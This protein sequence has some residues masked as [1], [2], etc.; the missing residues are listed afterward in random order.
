MNNRNRA[1]CLSLLMSVGVASAAMAANGFYSSATDV[2]LSSQQLTSASAGRDILLNGVV[3]DGKLAAGRNI[4]CQDCTISGSVAAGYDVQLE[5]CAQV[6]SVA[7]GHDAA[8]AASRVL[9]HLSSGNDVHLDDVTVEQTLQAG[10]QVTARNSTV[11]GLLS[12]G[13]N[14]ATLDHSNAQEIRFSKDMAWGGGMSNNSSIHINRGI[15]G[16]NVV[17]GGH[18]Q[19]QSRVSVGP[20]SLSSVNGYTIKGG[21]EQTTVITP[22]QS[23]YVNGHRV[24]GSDPQTY[25]AYRADHPD[26]PQVQGP[27]W[28]DGGSLGEQASAKPHK[29]NVNEPVVNILNLTNNSVV[30]GPVVFE[31][32]YG[33]VRIEKGSQLIGKVINGSIEHL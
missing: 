27:G 20:N 9:S 8:L 17:I 13:G 10:N 6:R 2:L 16:G 24:T 7:S 12:L 29:K 23:I 28:K 19:G 25:A 4:N 5:R 22:S 1:I 14:T 18:S 33:K 32:G 21:S 3:V 30:Q 11:S 31:S 26:A 15:L